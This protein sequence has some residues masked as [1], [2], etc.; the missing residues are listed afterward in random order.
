MAIQLGTENKRQV[1]IV[2]ALFA[3]IIV[4]AAGDL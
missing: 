1:Y 4:S 3:V 2:I